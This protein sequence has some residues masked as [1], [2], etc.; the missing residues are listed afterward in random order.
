MILIA[1]FL[2]KIVNSGKV[3]DG[4][5]CVNFM[6]LGDWG[7]WQEYPFSTPAQVKVAEQMKNLAQK[8]NISFII[9]VGDNFYPTGIT[10][11]TDPRIVYTFKNVY[12]RNSPLE[13]IPWFLVAGNHDHRMDQAKHQIE[14]SKHSDVWNFPD[15]LHTLRVKLNSK[16]K[17]KSVRFIFVD[18]NILC[19]LFDDF[20]LDQGFDIL[21]QTYYDLVERE[22][23]KSKKDDLIVVVGHH[24]IY[25]GMYGRLIPK[26]VNQNFK[27]LMDKY[28]VRAYISGHD[29]T[30]QYHTYRNKYSANETHL[31]ISGAGS[32][33]YNLPI[34]ETKNKIF[35]TKFYWQNTNKMDSSWASFKS[36]GFM[37][38]STSLDKFTF[39]FID[40]EGEI[41]YQNSF[42][43]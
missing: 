39:K 15:Y 29:H 21:N 19:S 20:R 40:E 16:N 12:L 25:S 6:A 34:I 36:G 1:I 8:M 22:L 18:T 2:F 9:S 26:C 35:D 28:L 32:G 27:N 43:I 13:G 33:S 17:L 3:I 30:L 14:Y 42:D 38:I 37:L 23:I 10:S 24:P 11:P 5:D 41:L 4:L 7:G 31:F